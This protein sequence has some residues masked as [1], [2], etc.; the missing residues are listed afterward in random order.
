M[1]GAGVTLGVD[2]VIKI[3][4]LTDW[5]TDSEERNKEKK[6]KKFQNLQKLENEN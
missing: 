2:A 4:W 5:L 1:D 3:N 6:K